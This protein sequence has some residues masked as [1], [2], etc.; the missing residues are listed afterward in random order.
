MSWAADVAR[1]RG[2]L[3]S[4]IDRRIAQIFGWTLTAKASP[5]GDSDA[6]ECADDDLDPATHQKGQRPVT[7]VEP[8]GVRSRP[9][10]K[11]RSLWLRLGAS[12]VV[13]IG[14]APTAAY[15]PQ[16]LDDGEAA[17]YNISKALVRL[18]KIGKLTIDSDTGAAV[19][20]DVIV[21]GGTLPVARKTDA[22][23]AT[24]PAGTVIVAVAAGV[25]TLNP[26]PIVLS[27]TIEA[28]APHFKG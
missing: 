26:N 2:E 16:D 17:I 22:I 15:G 10:A 6:V 20:Q 13:F 12:N 11:L 23:K 4:Y 19:P 24:I 5:L 28:G 3:L 7:R 1:L 21:N 14:I 18:W 8:F 25:G 27:G 9:P